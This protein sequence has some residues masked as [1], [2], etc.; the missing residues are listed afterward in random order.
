VRALKAE[1]QLREV[2]GRLGIADRARPFTRCL[3]DNAPLRAVAKEAV[4]A[5]LPPMVAASQDEFSTCGLCGR[6]YWK[7]SHWQRMNAVLARAVR[8]A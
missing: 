1:E 8:D 4:I 2:F 5:R 6:V 7:G 3:H